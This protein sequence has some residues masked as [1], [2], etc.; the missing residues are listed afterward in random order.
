VRVIVSGSS[1]LI[2]S[3]LV[4][5]LRARGDDVVRLVRRPA[6]ADDEAAWDPA[7]G[8]APAASVLDGCDA[9]VNLAGAGLGDHRWTADYKRQLHD[10]RV[11]GTRLLAAAAAS[12]A[13]PPRVFVNGSAIGFY[14]D[15]GDRVVDEDSPA[16]D[17]FLARL[18]QDWEAAAAPAADAGIRTV[19][20]R[21]GIVLSTRGG[22]L[23]KVLPLFKVGAGGRLGSGRQYVSWIARPDQIAATQ[24]VLDRDDIGGPVNLTAPEPVTNAQYTAAIAAVLRRPAV[25]TAP[26]AALRV[27]LGEFADTVVTGQRVMP[28]RLLAAGFEFGYPQLEPA[29]RALLDAAA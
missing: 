26:R 22:A 20:L 13:T 25:A 21:T 16:G 2:G 19:L 23:Q 18:C 6:R 5:G 15:T 14:G 10:S 12:M 1:G 24:F 17:D 7:A 29:L 11:A 27:A 9:V 28:Q 3:A 4:R 8:V